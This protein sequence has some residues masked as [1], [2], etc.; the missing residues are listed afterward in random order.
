MN[1]W[2]IEYCYY[3]KDFFAYFVSILN[4]DVC[5][6]SCSIPLFVFSANVKHRRQN[7]LTIYNACIYTRMIISNPPTHWPINNTSHN[8]CGRPIPT[9]SV[10]LDFIYTRCI[11]LASLISVTTIYIYIYIPALWHRVLLGT[12]SLKV[13]RPG[14]MLSKNYSKRE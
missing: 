9:Y 3:N 12:H 10:L 6:T 4:F 7:R 8:S 11:S 1:F 13:Q 2:V 5:S 14:G